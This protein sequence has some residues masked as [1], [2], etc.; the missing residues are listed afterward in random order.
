MSPD[1][2]RLR[3]ESRKMLVRV[4][5]VIRSGIDADL[6]PLVFYR[7]NDR[8]RTWT[9]LADPRNED[10]LAYLGRLGRRIR[11]YMH[12]STGYSLATFF[13][14]SDRSGDWFVW[15]V[16]F[17]KGIDKKICYFRFRQHGPLFALGDVSA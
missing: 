16:F 4:L 9:E 13:T 14:E 10:D 11:N 8:D 2:E 3:D 12:Q 1:E 17:N 15:E 6:A 5:Q 7:G